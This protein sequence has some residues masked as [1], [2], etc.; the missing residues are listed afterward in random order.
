MPARRVGRPRAS[1]GRR[2]CRRR[3]RRRAA[4]PATAKRRP[5]ALGRP[6]R[7][8]ATMAKTRPGRRPGRRPRRRRRRASCAGVPGGRED[9]EVP[10]QDRRAP[11]HDGDVQAEQNE[12]VPGPGGPRQQR[13][14]RPI[15]ADRTR[16]PG[17]RRAA[18]KP[19]AGV[20]PAAKSDQR[21]QAVDDQA[22]GDE[23]PGPA[24]ARIQAIRAPQ[25]DGHRTTI[26][27]PGRRLGAGEAVAQRGVAEPGDPPHGDADEE[28]RAARSARRSGRAADGRL[29]SDRPAAE[30]RAHGYRGPDRVDSGMLLGP[31]SRS[32]SARSSTPF[33]K[34]SRMSRCYL[35]RLSCSSN[36]RLSNAADPR[37]WLAK[38]RGRAPVADR[39]ASSACGLVVES[40]A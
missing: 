37:S 34:H 30:R 5:G 35:A 19:S 38:R 12:V 2:S 4:P 31:P 24:D 25:P 13:Q 27:P 22:D 9:E 16:S 10:D 18:Q 28:T 6:R 14:R 11:G 26:R 1:A 33:A 23:R 15:P 29:G 39:P 40:R 7:T 8:I 17:R 3:R 21:P 32:P 20:D 36:T